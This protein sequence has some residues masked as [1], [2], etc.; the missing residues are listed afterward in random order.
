M[1]PGLCEVCVEQKGIGPCFP[2]N[3][4]VLTRQF[5]CTST[6]TKLYCYWHKT[7]PVLAQNCTGTGT[8]LYQ[9]WHKTVPVLAQ[10]CTGTGTKLYRYWHK[11]VP[12][13]TLMHLN[14]SFIRMNGRSAGCFQHSVA[15]RDVWQ[16]WTLTY[17]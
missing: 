6:G 3:S 5:Y 2:P 7:E 4:S 15:L 9:Y 13:L 8:K 17:S 1:L 16:Q 10:K 14:T 11:T 12:V